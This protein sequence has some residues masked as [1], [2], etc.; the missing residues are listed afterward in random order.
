MNNTSKPDFDRILK[1]FRQSAD[2]MPWAARREVARRVAAAL[3]EGDDSEPILQLVH[4]LASDRKWEVRTDVA[5]LLLLLPEEHFTRVAALLS[6][7]TNSFV[8]RATERALDRR[9]RGQQTTRRA[10]QEHAQVQSQYAAMEKLHGRPVAEKA[11][12]IAERLFDHMVGATVHEMRG[13]L[14]PLKASTSSLLHHLDDGLI[15]PADFRRQL[16]KTAE[17]LG[18]LEQLLEDMRTYTQ[19]PPLERRQE[20]LGEI[21]DVA[22]LMV[23]EN[24]QAQGRWPEQVAVSK[25]IP[26]TLA[27]EMSRHLILIAIANLL[28]NAFEAFWDGAGQFRPGT[29]TIA[30]RSVD[31]ESVEIVIRDDGMGIDD[32]DL[33]E[34]VDFVPG[35]TSKKNWGTG[36]GLPIAQRNLAAHGGTIGIRSKVDQGTTVTINLPIEQEMGGEYEL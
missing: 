31:E 4:I 9:R 6:E 20:R 21:V 1:Q 22:L 13:I 16:T 7:D 24:L 10:R 2:A 26:E 12:K 28:K 15:D 5:D 14:T 36:F 17:R 18:F 23:R 8:R 25:D 11:R 27:A 32:E 30:A 33:E 19:P 3:A 34:I 35:K 29:I